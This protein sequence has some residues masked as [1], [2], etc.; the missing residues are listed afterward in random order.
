MFLMFF[1]IICHLAISKT[2]LAFHIFFLTLRLMK[3]TFPLDHFHKGSDA[4]EA[5]FI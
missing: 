5:I 3:R 1:N 2:A 4:G